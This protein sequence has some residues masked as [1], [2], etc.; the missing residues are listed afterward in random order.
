MGTIVNTP[1]AM[2]AEQRIVAQ[3]DSAIKAAATAQKQA[4]SQCRRLLLNSSAIV[5]D[6]VF[7]AFA[8][9]T[10][11]GLTAAQL[12][13]MAQVSKASLNL[14]QPGLI[15]DDVVEATITLPAA[16]ATTEGA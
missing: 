1:T 11:T 4:Y 15:V 12:V 5:P 10:T 7:A 9:N 14:F 6:Q 13:A 3:L 16:P 8:A 2:T